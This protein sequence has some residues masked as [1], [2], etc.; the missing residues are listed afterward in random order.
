MAIDKAAKFR[1]IAERRTNRVLDSL[2]LL[3]QCSNPRLYD[4]SEDETRKMFRAIEREFKRVKLS[5]DQ[6]N[7]RPRFKL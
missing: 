5:F 1:E 6:N 3:G 4:Y 2:R 7:Q